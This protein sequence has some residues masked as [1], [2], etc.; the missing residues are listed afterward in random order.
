[1]NDSGNYSATPSNTT[2]GAGLDSRRYTGPSAPPPPRDTVASVLNEQEALLSSI[3]ETINH[4]EGALSPILGPMM[5]SAQG[6]EAEKL[7]RVRTDP[8]GVVL[9]VSGHNR[10]LEFLIRRLR[11]IGER[12]EL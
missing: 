9:R 5:P 4:L 11:D 2:G 1:M 10:G 3:H 7:A 6:S 8:P 12:L